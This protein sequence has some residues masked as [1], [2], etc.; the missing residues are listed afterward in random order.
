MTA[1][2]SARRGGCHGLAPRRAMGALRVGGHGGPC[3]YVALPRLPPFEMAAVSSA[4]PHAAAR[5]LRPDGALAV[6]G[7][8]PPAAVLLA[9][10]GRFLRVGTLS[11]HA[12]TRCSPHRRF[13]TF[14]ELGPSVVLG[15]GSRSRLGLGLGSWLGL[16]QWVSV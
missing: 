6:P 12:A 10:G 16:E 9:R 2:A 3:F 1:A 13:V 15:L 4:P 11:G 7:P 5:R 14:S 8:P